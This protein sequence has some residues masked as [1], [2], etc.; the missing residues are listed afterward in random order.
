MRDRPF[1][2]A[3]ES[4]RPYSEVRAERGVDPREAVFR[5]IADLEADAAETEDT[6]EAKRLRCEAEGLRCS[7]EENKLRR[8]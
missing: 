7:L 4:P 3:G 6:D 5:M 2:T 1:L 8:S